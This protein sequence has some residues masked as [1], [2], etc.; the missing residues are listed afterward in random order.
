[1]AN[2][3][4]AIPTEYSVEVD[5][6]VYDVKITPTGFMEVSEDGEAPFTPVEGALTSSMQGMVLKVKVNIGD[7]VKKG[8]VVAVLEAMKMEND[9][10]AEE[11]GTVTELYINEGDAINAGDALMLIK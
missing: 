4:L 7:K 1:M 11:D 6:D 9:V 5:G 2:E 3:G 8:D 10:H